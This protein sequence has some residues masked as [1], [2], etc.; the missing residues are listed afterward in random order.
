[1][2]GILRCSI[3]RTGHFKNQRRFCKDNFEVCKTFTY[4]Q[5]SLLKLQNFPN[6]Q[7]IQIELETLWEDHSTI[8]IRNE[9]KNTNLDPELFITGQD[10][11]REVIISPATQT[12][13]S[14]FTQDDFLLFKCGIPEYSS[15]DFTFTGN[16]VQKS[17]QVDAKLKGDITIINPST[18]NSDF[19][20]L[21]RIKSENCTIDLQAANLF[22]KKYIEV[23]NFTLKKS[24]G[25]IINVNRMG[26][27][28][29]LHA[30]VV[31]TS[32]TIGT[33]WINPCD[34]KNNFLRSAVNLFQGKNSRFDVDFLNGP[35]VIHCE[36]SKV[37]IGEGT[38]ESCECRF[39]GN[40]E[41]E[42]YIRTMAK[43][44]MDV[45]NFVFRVR[46]ES[47]LVQKV[48]QNYKGQVLIVDETELD[49][50]EEFEDDSNQKVYDRYCQDGNHSIV[51][52]KGK[53]ASVEVRY[54]NAEMSL[55]EFMM[56]KFANNQKTKKFSEHEIPNK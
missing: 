4:G 15:I 8:Q 41:A 25:G 9:S 11:S 35:L 53:D 33:L 18:S 7:K 27:S 6:N 30:K 3:Q 36:D 45:T 13:N 54:E 31:N 5:D 38:L 39:E 16:L 43:R 44:Y 37:R 42:I 50:A 51:I 21:Q 24:L 48:N 32:M 28:K 47:K 17:G 49:G 10:E 20:D 34:I 22:V 12:S 46:D 29:Q 26:I 52:L 40:S 14:F 2:N 1:M 23:K 56:K 19:V 55:K